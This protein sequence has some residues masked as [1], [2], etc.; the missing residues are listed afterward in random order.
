VPE[1]LEQEGPQYLDARTFADED[2]E[3]RKKQAQDDEKNLAHATDHPLQKPLLSGLVG[4][5]VA[6][7]DGPAAF[8]LGVE[9]G[10]E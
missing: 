2:G 10:A 9:F 4:G 3:E 1:Q 7:L 5:R 6:A 8:D